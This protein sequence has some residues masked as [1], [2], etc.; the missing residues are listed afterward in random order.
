MIGVDTTD[1]CIFYESTEVR[2]HNERSSATCGKRSKICR[3]KLKKTWYLY[4]VSIGTRPKI[5]PASQQCETCLT[6]QEHSLPNRRTYQPFF[7]RKERSTCFAFFNFLI[8]S[9]WTQLT[10]YR[11]NSGP[12]K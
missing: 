2:L 3:P 10:L 11:Q 9:G 12:T 4:S 7:Y 8:S 5:N 6:T 1:N